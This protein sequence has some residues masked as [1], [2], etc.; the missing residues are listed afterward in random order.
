MTLTQ[1]QIRE[2]VELLTL[3]SYIVTTTGKHTR[4]IADIAEWRGELLD[5]YDPTPE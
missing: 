3:C 5:H 4:L 2:L 1:S